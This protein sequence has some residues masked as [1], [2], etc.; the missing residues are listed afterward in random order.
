MRDIISTA[1]RGEKDERK[2]KKNREE[3][4]KKKKKQR[5]S[6]KRSK[7]KVDAARLKKKRLLFSWIVLDEKSIKIEHVK[8]S[9]ITRER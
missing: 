9:S 8:K 7:R 6:K 2:E 3:K 1:K 4:E 5:S